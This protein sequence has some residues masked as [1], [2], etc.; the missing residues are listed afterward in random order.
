[1]QRDWLDLTLAV[2]VFRGRDF[3]A[4]DR[5]QDRRL[6]EAAGRGG[7]RE[8]VGHGVRTVAFAGAHTG[9]PKRLIFS[10]RADS[11]SWARNGIHATCR[12]TTLPLRRPLPS[13]F[14]GPCPPTLARSVPS[15]PCWVH[16]IKHAAHLPPRRRSVRIFTRRGNDW[17]NRV[18]SI[19]QAIGSLPAATATLDGEAV[20]CDEQG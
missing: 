8:A 13:G 17:T 14:I 19:S 3:A 11:R 2:F 1:M 12:G 16:E 9:A 15:R 4:L 18:P 10:A 5:S 20:I 6:V 7:C